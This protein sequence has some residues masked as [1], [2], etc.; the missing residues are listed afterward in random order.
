MSAAI[1]TRSLLLDD[2]GNY[3]HVA[4]VTFN[5][6]QVLPVPWNTTAGVDVNNLFDRDSPAVLSAVTN[7]LDS[8]S[9]FPAV[10]AAPLHPAL[11][12]ERAA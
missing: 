7:S 3:H 4:T 10:N 9:A 6:M 12:I 8:A 5:A 11:L 1:I 2:T